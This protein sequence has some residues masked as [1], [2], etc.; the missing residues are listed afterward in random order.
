MEQSY[1]TSA[2][3]IVGDALTRNIYLDIPPL[4]HGLWNSFLCKGAELA[5][6]VVLSDEMLKMVQESKPDPKDST[7]IV[8]EYYKPWWTQA[9]EW[10]EERPEL[11][12]MDTT[13]DFHWELVSGVPARFV[14][15]E[16]P[17]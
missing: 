14:P 9:A 4:L 5:T 15:I 10:K 17:C 13:F 8:K 6:W 7:S 16:M 2:L 12:D 3:S 11:F 1:Q